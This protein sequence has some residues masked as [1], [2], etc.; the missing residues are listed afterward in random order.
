MGQ[1]T[2]YHNL[3]KN[4]FNENDYADAA[5][6]SDPDDIIKMS[7]RGNALLIDLRN[8]DLKIETR[9]EH[10]WARRQFLEKLEKKEQPKKKLLIDVSYDSDGS[11]ILTYPD[12]DGN[13]LF[14]I[15]KEGYKKLE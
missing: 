3:T 1:S 4:W 15:T 9:G 12:V 5:E 11:P 10:D 7:F 8:E 14:Q 6:N 2:Y 13:P